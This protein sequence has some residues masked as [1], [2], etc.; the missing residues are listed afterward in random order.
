MRALEI[1]IATGCI[2][3]WSIAAL[4]LLSRYKSTLRLSDIP[5]AAA[6]GTLISGL[7][8]AITLK[9]GV[10]VFTTLWLIL[11]VAG[12][13]A[14]LVIYKRFG[15]STEVRLSWDWLWNPLFFIC[16][17]GL[18][19]VASLKMGAGPYPLIFFN[20]DSPLRLGH[21]FSVLRGSTY[22][23]EN[24]FVAGTTHAY[25]YGA[26]ASAA[27][28]SLMSG[29]PLHK[30]MFWLFCPLLIVGIVAQTIQLSADIHG[31]GWR[32]RLSVV[33]FLPYV[34]LASTAF[35]PIGD[36]IVPSM[37]ELIGG[38]GA[39][40]GQSD[41]YDPA[42][43]G[44][45]VWDASMLS[46]LFLLLVSTRFASQSIGRSTYPLVF[47]VAGLTLFCKVD[48][49]PVIYSILGVALI[50]QMRPGSMFA[51]S[52][53]IVGLLLLP[54]LFLMLF[55]YGEGRSEIA[56]ISLRSV[57]EAF[58]FFDWRWTKTRPYMIEIAWI[59]VALVI[60]FFDEKIVSGL[61][62]HRLT[63][64]MAVAVAS[65]ASYLIVALIF[66]PKTGVQFSLGMWIGAAVLGSCLIGVRTSF[67][68]PLAWAAVF[69]ILT[70]ATAGQ[71][72]K[73]EHAFVAY[74]FPSTV[75]EFSDNA[76]ISEAMSAI[77]LDEAQ[78]VAAFR[79]YVDGYP[80][81]EKAY[82]EYSGS[83]SKE[84]WGKKHYQAQGQ[85]E[86][87]NLPISSKTVVVTNDFRYSKWDDTQPQLVAMFGHRT[88]SSHPRLFPGR[89]GFNESAANRVELQKTL[90]SRSFSDQSEQIF[91]E[92]IETARKEGWTH[93][94]MR[95]DLD[96]GFAELDS[97][98]IPLPKLFE[99]RRYAVFEFRW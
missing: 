18:T 14:V 44:N 72:S 76:L 52:V 90:L 29:A 93:Y 97:G 67:L 28:I 35:N 59:V 27:A 37:Q 3:G 94:L 99:N 62:S 30:A 38:I 61:R 57:D 49:A 23:P 47:I 83:L 13:F 86:N 81:L 65:F 79:A 4:P 71:A 40:L 11:F 73:I 15:L 74:F 22:P 1:G 88:Y 48:M 66:V 45:G 60:V 17:G 96:D 80:D 9:A 85:R 36:G 32:Q 75:E 42:S 34:M 19:L 70:V 54:P 6:L 63:L 2:V 26:P 31:C 21:A 50:M 43:F 91:Q 82:Q 8:F 51:N 55:G 12:S 95:K 84:E 56:T 33:L 5:I 64:A 10:D 24:L 68:K 77:P 69:P 98:S 20:D 58:S 39:G 41:K 46:G 16:I 92:V 53:S 78:S 7:V 87:R 89:R 25:H